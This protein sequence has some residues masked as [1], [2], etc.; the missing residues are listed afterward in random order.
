MAIP[1]YGKYILDKI[2]IA[3]T[4]ITLTEI[5]LFSALIH[6]LSIEKTVL[7]VILIATAFLTL[8]LIVIKTFLTGKYK[9]QRA[10]KR[11]KKIFRF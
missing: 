11:R 1:K 10:K 9:A 3:A 8:L 5:V 4:L 7:L 6:F 2:I